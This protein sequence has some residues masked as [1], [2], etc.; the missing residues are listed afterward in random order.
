MGAKGGGGG[1]S[2]MKGVCGGTRGQFYVLEENR[3]PESDSVHLN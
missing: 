1:E 3:S 2:M